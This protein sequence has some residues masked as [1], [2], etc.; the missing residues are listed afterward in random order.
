MWHGVVSGLEPGARDK[1]RQLLRA[2]MAAGN[3]TELS[4][5]IERVKREAS[6][7]VLANAWA[8]RCR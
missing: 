3:L 6:A 7:A 1:T 4:R 8:H 2:A 5:V